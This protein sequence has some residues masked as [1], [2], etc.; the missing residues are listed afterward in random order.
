MDCVVVVGSSGQLGHDLVEVLHATDRYEVV[1]L[2]HRRIEC[3]DLN[4]VRAALLPLRAQ[5]IINCAAFVRVDDCE[6]QAREAFAV[7]ALGALHVARAASESGAKCVYISTDYVFDGSKDSPYIE[8]DIAAPINVYGASKLAGE[9]LVRQAAPHGLIVRVASLFGKTGARGKG[10]NF[11][12]TILAKAREGEPLKVVNDI[13]VSPTYAGDASR[14]IAQLIAV[15]AQG[16]VHAVNSGTC[17]WY[18][19]AE[20]ALKLC[21]FSAPIEAVSSLQFA[22]PARRAKNSALVS[23]RLVSEFSITMPHWRDALRAY[24]IEKGHLPK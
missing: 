10:G 3:T 19:F 15:D 24:L 4:S 22:T 1:A 6:A 17:T 18:E 5:V 7:N 9:H 11:I 12:E 21:Q 20:T 14:A 16:I 2:D 13:V 8:C 23:A